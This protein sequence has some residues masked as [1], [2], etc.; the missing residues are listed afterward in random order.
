[1]VSIK[2]LSIVALAVIGMLSLASVNSFAQKMGIVDG[3]KVLDS[4]SEYQTASNKLNGIIKSWQD[5]LSMMNK[6]LQDK[7]DSYQKILETMSKEAK[8]KAD[9]EL[10][11]MQSDIQNYNVQKSDQQNGEIVKVRKDIMEPIVKNVKDAINAVAKKKK[12]D[13]VLD[14]TQVAYV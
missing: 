10:K 2:K 8:E 3:Q 12:L 6:A 13:I 4:Y 5:T 7:F 11:K 9:N 1:M 14:K